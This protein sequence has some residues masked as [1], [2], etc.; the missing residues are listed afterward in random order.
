MSSP[1]RHRI[2]EIFDQTVAGDR[3]ARNVHRI[4]VVLILA[5]ITAVVIDSVPAN[6]EA[7]GS[8]LL[9]V[10]I[11]TVAGFA[12]EYGLRLWAAVEH[13]PLRHLS[14]WRAR[15]AYAL[16]PHSIIDLLAIVPA[17][18]AFFVPA[19]LGVL[20]VLRLIRYFKLARYSPGMASLTDAVWR[21][22][23]SLLACLVIFLSAVLIAAALMHFVEKGAQPQTFGS[24]PQAMYWAMITLTTVGYG[25]VV[26]A[27]PAGKLVASLTAIAGIVMLA[28]PVG[29]IAS[30]FAREIQGRDFVVT[31]SMVARVPLFS[32]LDA[33]SVAEIMRRLKSRTAEPNE[34]ICREGVPSQALFLIASG[35]IDLELPDGHVVLGEGHFFG[36]TAVIRGVERPGTVK[37]LRAARLLVLDAHDLEAIMDDHPEIAGKVRTVAGER[38]SPARPAAA[39]P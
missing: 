6:A 32:G 37:A 12:I 10:E 9:A 7:Y 23:R 26:P 29:I 31:W 20:L 13:P 22:R 21:E 1:L 19:D 16:L 4:I 38:F 27:T 2:Y 25:D 5:N 14:P 33:A 28:L 11:V 34:I 36:E 3:V 35:E 24:I 15:L 17:V 39:V 18:L 30:A 8:L